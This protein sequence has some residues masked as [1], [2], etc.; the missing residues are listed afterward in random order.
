MSGFLPSAEIMKTGLEAASVGLQ[1]ISS[2]VDGRDTRPVY[3]S[4][5]LHIREATVKEP[6]EPT[7]MMLD[8][9]ALAIASFNGSMFADI[10]AKKVFP[11]SASSPS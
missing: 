3:S 6:P 2:G 10:A 11:N 4:C 5:K 1:M 7:P 9:A 8:S